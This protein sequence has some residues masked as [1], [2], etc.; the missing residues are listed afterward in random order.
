[1]RA[2]VEADSALEP[3]AVTPHNQMRR[4]GVEHFVGDD[5]SL[6]AL[7]QHVDPLHA[8]HQIADFCGQVLA[9]PLAQIGAHFEQQIA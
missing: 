9:L 7:G 1:M 8:R 5:S 4:D 3:L 2:R 6:P